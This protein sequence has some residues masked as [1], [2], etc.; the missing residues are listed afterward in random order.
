LYSYLDTNFLTE[1]IN[2][3]LA[4]TNVVKNITKIA[5]LSNVGSPV[6]LNEENLTIAES[7]TTMI[8]K[9]IMKI[10]DVLLVRF[11]VADATI[12]SLVLR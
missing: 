5:V 10:N 6:P 2:S 12:L 4:V 3:M 7:S 11:K 8:E 9:I 1:F